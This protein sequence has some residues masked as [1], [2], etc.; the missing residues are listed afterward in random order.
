VS[1]GFRDIAA[2]EYPTEK[3]R[4]TQVYQDFGNGL[5]RE[6]MAQMRKEVAHNQLD[7]RSVHTA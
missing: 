7:V 3:E 6:R 1:S 5:G 2:G 4:V